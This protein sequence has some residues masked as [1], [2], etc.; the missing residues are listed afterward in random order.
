MDLTDADAQAAV[1]ALE[2]DADVVVI[3]YRPGVPEQLKIDYE[4]LSIR[5]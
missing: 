1:H 3:N 5:N 4:T 2:E